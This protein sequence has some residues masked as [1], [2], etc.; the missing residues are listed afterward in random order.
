MIFAMR[1]LLYLSCSVICCPVIFVYADGDDCQSVITSDPPYDQD[2][3]KAIVLLNTSID[4][5]CSGSSQSDPMIIINGT[6]P[7][8]LNNRMEVDEYS[9]QG[10]TWSNIINEGE[11]EQSI[12]ITVRPPYVDNRTNISCVFG[13]A[14]DVIQIIPVK[15]ITIVVLIDAYL[16]SVS[17]LVYV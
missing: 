9:A 12:N 17:Q 3:L 2:T 6:R 7:I 10:I 5:T 13:C 1:M 15:G 8:A 14:T 4:L 11:G 16:Y